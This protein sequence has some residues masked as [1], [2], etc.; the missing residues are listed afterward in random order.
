L[1]TL[2]KF[3]TSLVLNPGVGTSEVKNFFKVAKAG[4]AGKRKQLINNL[5]AGLKISKSEIHQ[6]LSFVDINPQRRAETLT[7][8][9]WQKITS[10]L[11][12]RD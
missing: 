4:F 5:A 6:K 12:S 11:F 1:A 10:S 3:F 7:I 2:K 9:E 8:E